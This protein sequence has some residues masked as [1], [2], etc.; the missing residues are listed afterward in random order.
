ML[1]LKNCAL[2][3]SVSIKA[4]AEIIEKVSIFEEIDLSYNQLTP[5]LTDIIIPNLSKMK[6]INL[7]YNKIGRRGV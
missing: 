6:R 1:D 7:A 5:D 2:G 3:G 4:I